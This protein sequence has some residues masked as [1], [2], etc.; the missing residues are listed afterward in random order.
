MVYNQSRHRK[1][2]DEDRSRSEPASTKRHD[3]T[4]SQKRHN[5]NRPQQC[6]TVGTCLRKQPSE[7]ASNGTIEICFKVVSQTAS[8]K[9]RH[10]VD[11]HQNGKIVSCRESVTICEASDRSDHA[12]KRICNTFDPTTRT[13]TRLK[14]LSLAIDTI[15]RLLNR[16][17][18]FLA[19]Q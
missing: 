14:Y 19:C 18:L 1:R 3:R 11:W 6:S 13:L 7:V 10:Y 9:A 8:D 5:G 16:L 15:A 17:T 12:L 4:R 2:H